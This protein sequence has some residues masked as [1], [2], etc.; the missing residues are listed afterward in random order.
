MRELMIRNSSRSI[1]TS[2]SSWWILASGASPFLIS[3]L[4]VREH[5]D[6]HDA[7]HIEYCAAEERVSVPGQAQGLGLFF[8]DFVR[9][10]DDP[11]FPNIPDFC[12][13]HVM[14]RT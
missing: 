2:D 13:P 4:R 8:M 6:P 12:K 1:A 11:K 7:D 14:W 3:V 10:G 9:H 5:R